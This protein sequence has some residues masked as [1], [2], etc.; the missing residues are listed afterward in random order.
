MA[1][2]SVRAAVLVPLLALVYLSCARYLPDLPGDAD[3]SHAVAA[4]IGAAAVTAAVVAL[5]EFHD[6]MV[7]LTLVGIGAGLLVGTLDSGNAGA[8]ATLPEVLLWA[9]GGMLFA[10]LLGTP[11]VAL[12]VPVFMAILDCVGVG[13][14]GALVDDPVRVGDVLTL[15]LPAWGGGG[16]AQLAAIDVAVLAALLA[17]AHRYGLRAKATAIAMTAVLAVSVAIDLLTSRSV[18]TVAALVLAYLVVNV[19]LG[20]RLLVP[21][22]EG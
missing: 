4:A 7:A 5:L 16:A 18:P 2:E 20:D 6:S 14:S 21:A 3:T 12:A 8:G 22:P 13:Q 19:D 15:E 17:W 1:P 9:C 10:H 11:Q